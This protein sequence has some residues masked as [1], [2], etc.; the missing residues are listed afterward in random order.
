MTNIYKKD[1]EFEEYNLPTNSVGIVPNVRLIERQSKK[2]LNELYTHIISDLIDKDKEV[3]IIQHSEE[4]SVI[5]QNIASKFKHSDQVHQASSGLNA[6]ELEKFIEQLDYM[7]ASRYHS[8]IHAFKNNTPVIAI[9]WATKY[10]E[11]L[12][13]LGQGQ[14]YIEGRNQIDIGD[15]LE[16]IHSIEENLKTQE[17][18]IMLNRE[19]ILQ[20]D[21][22][23]EVFD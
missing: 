19:E 2:Q 14:F 8:I 23:S 3:W 1:P 17:R 21:L 9:G 13:D 15:T 6:I 11:L 7:V 10:Q 12:N 20:E 22:F 18:T 4:D 5:C 16:K